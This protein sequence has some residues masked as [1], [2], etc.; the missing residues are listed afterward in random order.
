M[1]LRIS[2]DGGYPEII[3]E[4]R[5]ALSSTVVGA[6]VCRYE[7][8]DQHGVVLQVSSPLLCLMFPQHGP[9]K[10]HQRQIR[11]VSWQRE[12]TARYPQELVRGLIHSDGCR[13]INA[14]EVRLP[15]GRVGRY[16]YGRYFFSNLS[17]DIRGIFCAHCELLG[18]RWTQSNSRNISVSDRAS[19][20]KLDGFVGPKS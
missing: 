16:E 11:L 6:S 15:S 3:E 1:F 7:R 14:F 19:V 17:L 8:P 13:V 18:I 4:C 12:I 2:L 5:R 10:K 20:E 9:G